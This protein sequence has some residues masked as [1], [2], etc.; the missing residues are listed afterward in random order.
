[1]AITTY[2]ELQT[3]IPIWLSRTTQSGFSSR[4]PE[5]IALAED[6]LNAEIALRINQVFTTLT[7]TAAS[8]TVALPSD[9]VEPYSLQHTDL[10]YEYL[11]PRVADDM[12]NSLTS[13]RP[14][15]WAIDES[16]II[17]ERPCDAVYTLRFGYR[18]KFA[19]S[20][21]APTNWLLTNHP[22][23]YLYAS[24]YE[25][26]AFIDDGSEFEAKMRA[27]R[28]EA[29]ALA[30]QVAARSKSI[31]VSQVDSALLAI[32]NRLR[33]NWYPVTF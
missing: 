25:A 28:D 6:H 1:M 33:G 9:F 8:R 24:L 26:G 11:T 3:A 7:T 14:S 15:Q 29:V 13:G 21:S 5:F 10:A 2:A 22:R 32:G 31:A 20:D 19:L 27:R 16:N 30:K 17:F 4:V 18:K 12:P 23:A